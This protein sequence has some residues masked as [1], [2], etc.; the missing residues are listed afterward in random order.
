MFSFGLSGILWYKKIKFVFSLHKTP[1]ISQLE[2]KKEY[3]YETFGP[4]KRKNYQEVKGSSPPLL[5]D[6]V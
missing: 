3:D 4:V 2:M 1:K 5:K 6:G